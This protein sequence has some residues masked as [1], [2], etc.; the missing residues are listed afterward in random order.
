MSAIGDRIKAVRESRGMTQEQFSEF[1]GIG[2]PNL[3]R[4]ET[5]R[6]EPSVSVLARIS[7]ATG[8]SMDYYAGLPKTSVPKKDKSMR[9]IL[10]AD[11]ITAGV[12]TL[13]AN[14]AENTAFSVEQKQELQKLVRDAIL[15]FDR[16][17]KSQ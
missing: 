16:E 8:I 6:A 5:G 14:G 17:Q 7:E 11:P 13:A 9:E 15:R 10:D 12:H 2:R 1:A 4:Y 3:A